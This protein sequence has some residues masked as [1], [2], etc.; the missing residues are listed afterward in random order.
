MALETY[1]KY[2]NKVMADTKKDI[3]ELDTKET[4]S[5]INKMHKESK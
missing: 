1:Y 3:K 4:L 2:L 5:L